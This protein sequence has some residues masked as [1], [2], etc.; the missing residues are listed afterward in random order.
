[1]SHNL[2]E[3]LS[4]GTIPITEYPELMYPPL[5]DGVNCIAFRGAAGLRDAVDRALAMSAADAQ[6]LSKGAAA[7]YDQY[8]KPDAAIRRLLESPGKHVRL[9]LLPFLK[10]GGGY[11]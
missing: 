10:L 7:Y 2:I 5:E 11:A 6:R 4:V 9:R 3:A 1:M 8:L